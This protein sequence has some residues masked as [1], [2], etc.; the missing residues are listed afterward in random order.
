MQDHLLFGGVPDRV[1]VL[2]R[3]F[4]DDFLR[5]FAEGLYLGNPW[6]R[7][8]FAN[9]YN[10][11]KVWAR[12][13]DTYHWPKLSQDLCEMP[14]LTYRHAVSATVAAMDKA[15]LHELSRRNSSTL[16]SCVRDV[17]AAHHYRRGFMK[18]IYPQSDQSNLL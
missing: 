10:A 9:Q 18:R 1:F 12:I 5:G 11:E 16:S 8:S 2:D 14:I 3:K 6:L 7:V 17:L 13:I 4:A 15:Y